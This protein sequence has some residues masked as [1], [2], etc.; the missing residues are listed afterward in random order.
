MFDISHTE[1]TGLTNRLAGSGYWPAAA[2]GCLAEKKYSRAVEICREGLDEEPQSVSGRVIYAR[3]LY[4]AGQ[5]DSATEQFYRVLAL[6]PENIVALKYLGDIKHEAGD[7]YTAVAYYRRVL[8]IDPD[9]HELCC[10]VKVE[11]KETTRTV[12][13]NRGGETATPSSVGRLRTVPF[14]TETMGDL[15][16]SQG[17]ARLAAEVFRSLY[18]RT[19]LP[20]LREKLETAEKRT[21]IKER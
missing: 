11:T 4:H 2:A 7:T 20:R 21:T 16:L 18:E 19:P 10:P 13:I 3:S 5:T 9:S 15:Y 12:T 8:E 14:V 6:D 1:D 17:H